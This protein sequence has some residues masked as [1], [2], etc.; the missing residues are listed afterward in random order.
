MCE[1]RNVDI[2]S[3]ENQV[4]VLYPFSTKRYPDRFTKKVG[5]D[6]CILPEI[7]YLWSKGIK[8]TESCCGHNKR[9]GYI[10]VEEVYAPL[11]KVL[12]YERDMSCSN[13]SNRNDVYS[14]NS[15]NQ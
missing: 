12:G 10:A 4:T 8:T 14:I 15:D 7:L 3:Y 6:K 1:C 13:S 9:A 2:G 11:M 5:I